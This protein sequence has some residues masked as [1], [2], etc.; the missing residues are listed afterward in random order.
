[1]NTCS[2]SLGGMRDAVASLPSG[3]CVDVNE[4]PGRVGGPERKAR[5]REAEEEAEEAIYP[6]HSWPLS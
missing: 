2:R 3:L 6:T 1:M 4:V 5:V